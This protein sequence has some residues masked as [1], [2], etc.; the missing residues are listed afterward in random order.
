[1]LLPW[2]RAADNAAVALRMSG[3][4]RSSS[5]ERATA[6]LDHLGLAGF[7]GSYPRELSGGMRQRV[8]F[9]RTLMAGADVLLLDEP[10][11]ALDDRA[12]ALLQGLLRDALHRD[13]RR[14]RP[15]RDVQVNVDGTTV[16]ELPGRERAGHRVGG[17]DHQPPGADRPAILL[18][19]T[20]AD[21]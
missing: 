18:R 7:A 15:R 4:D 19:E 8:A 3:G 6:M 14:V 11:A 9:A 20:I 16:G 2:K 5:R 12:I 17:F 21:E 13:R 1:M 10:F